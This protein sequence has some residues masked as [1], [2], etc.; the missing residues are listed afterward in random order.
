M[1][2]RGS[3]VAALLATLAHPRWWLLALAG[4]LVRGGLV[5]LIAPIVV[6]PTVAGIAANLSPAIVVLASGGGV[7]VMPLLLVAGAIFTWVV[8]AG[9]LGAW[10]D[11]ALVAEAGSDEDLGLSGVNGDTLGGRLPAGLGTARLGPHLVT[12]V[13]FAFAA[14]VLIGVAYREATSPGAPTVPFVIRVIGEAL[15]PVVILLATWLL[16]EA[17]GGLA[18]RQLLVASRPDASP[19][20]ARAIGLGSV[21]A[22]RWRSLVTVATT[23]LV[24]LVVAGLGALAA[25]RA[26]SELRR[27]LTDGAD[28]TVLAVG[29]LVFIAVVLGW[30]ALLALALAW[31]STV[32]TI[33]SA[34]VTRPSSEASEASR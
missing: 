31:R 33:R 22:V 6:P 12:A 1:A 23:N 29:L 7:P 24:T 32:W 20:V 18:L 27:F 14:V 30:L 17:A 5:V 9:W 34:I 2:G 16:A 28:V 19:H 15:G 25:A 4:F 3:L 13:V 26:W 11:A 21:A 10:F 8:V